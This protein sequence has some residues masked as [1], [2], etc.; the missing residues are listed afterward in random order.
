M[1]LVPLAIAIVTTSTAEAVHEAVAEG[2]R[3]G[4]SIDGIE[5]KFADSS[6]LLKTLVEQGVRAE[7]RDDG[8]IQAQFENGTITYYKGEN[9]KYY[10]NISDVNDIECLAKNIETLEKDYGRNV[11]SFTYEKVISN[12]PDN[13]E[14]H[15]EEILSDNSILIT[16]NVTE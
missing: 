1:F 11:Q 9:E 14:L 6:L 4:H 13:M 8:S 16:L 2:R 5:T 7:K 12:I 10:M 3:N 15:K